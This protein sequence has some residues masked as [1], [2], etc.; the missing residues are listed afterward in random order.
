MATRIIQQLDDTGGRLERGSSGD[1]YGA[2]GAMGFAHMHMHTPPVPVVARTRVTEAVG[3]GPVSMTMGA[4]V[5]ESGAGARKTS[6]MET[7]VREK[8]NPNT[9][10]AYESGWRGFT[11]YMREEVG[12]PHL[13]SID[14]SA[15]RPCD[16]A[17]Y[18]RR[19]VEE[20]GVA[21][22][23][24]AGDRAAIA[25]GL[26]YVAA[27]RDMHLHPL[28]ADTMRLC[29][30]MAA[31]PKPKQ[32]VSAELMRDIV[33][34]HDASPQGEVQWTAER[35]VFLMLLMMVG[36]LRESEAV[37]LRVSDV[38]LQ[39]DPD[40]VPSSS[41]RALVAAAAGGASTDAYTTVTST[42]AS[43]ST[44]TWQQR[45]MGVTPAPVAAWSHMCILVRQSKTDQRKKGAWVVLAP[46]DANPA[47]CPLRRL[48]RYQAALQRANV[49]SEYLF[50]TSTGGGMARSTPCG[51]VQNAV[52]AANDRAAV[53]AV[54]ATVMP[55]WQCH[56]SAAASAGRARVEKWGAPSTYGSHSMRRGG[57]TEARKSGVDMLEIQRHGR[58]TS[59]AVWGYVGP[60]T[61]ER[62]GVSRNL[63]PAT[64]AAG[65]LHAG[66]GA[67][68]RG[69]G[70]ALP[71]AAAGGAVRDR[72][73]VWSSGGGQQLGAT[74]GA[75][76]R[77]AST[78]YGV[79]MHMH[80]ST[81]PPRV[82]GLGARRGGTS[83]S[84]AK[85]KF[86][87]SH[88]GSYYPK[89]SVMS[90]RTSMATAVGVIAADVDVVLHTPHAE[91]TLT[92]SAAPATPSRTPV[93][94]VGGR[95]TGNSP[96]K[97]RRQEEEDDVT[98][99]GLLEMESWQ[100]SS[101]GEY[102]PGVDV[103]RKSTAA[104]TRQ[105]RTPKSS[106]VAAPR[107]S[108]G[109]A[110]KQRVVLQRDVNQLQVSMTEQRGDAQ[111]AAGPV[112]TTRS[113]SIARR[114]ADA[115]AAAAAGPGP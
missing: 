86:K 27:A 58:W 105:P 74:G 24:V 39:S 57:V 103:T 11:R 17:D 6:F 62:L 21:A 20:D 113:S 2:G 9:R 80:M 35:N 110:M 72:D 89:K 28:V 10:R 32:H 18:L 79:G 91:L 46:N 108:P 96:R 95:G 44:S 101:D 38:E 42:A 68:A 77:E 78:D 7:W 36:M 34:H 112:R 22:G 60:T 90:Q 13:D 83:S 61:Q 1:A 111:A 64:P 65:G 43:T 107:R 106:G 85:S 15:V 67:G 69:G 99:E 54:T 5:T 71:G 48:M 29:M 8:S 40:A 49:N 41:S 100:D 97:R 12:A 30:N 37:E 102:V 33:E 92:D 109:V 53:A 45:A 75:A 52:G 87:A 94:V 55:A 50:P 70:T 114:T 104:V 84:P 3:P 31:Q 56:W 93:I 98:V 14:T 25:D 59:M 26:K 73:S 16:I 115:A 4:A 76:R 19:R 51:I 63:F 82:S 88:S 23:T 81:T 66:A 47:M